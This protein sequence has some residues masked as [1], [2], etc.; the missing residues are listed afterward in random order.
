MICLKSHLVDCVFGTC[1]NCIFCSSIDVYSNIIKVQIWLYTKIA[2]KHSVQLRILSQMSTNVALDETI[3]WRIFL[4]Y[5]TLIYTH[6][7][8]KWGITST[9][10]KFSTKRCT[11]WLLLCKYFISSFEVPFILVTVQSPN[12]HSV[13]TNF[14]YS[15]LAYLM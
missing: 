2:L 8:L 11:T 6:T 13:E 1:W 9:E 4:N 12:L 15:A 3:H 10:Y 5:W 7:N 14:F